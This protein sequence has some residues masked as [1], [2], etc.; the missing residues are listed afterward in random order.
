MLIS[1][2]V[3]VSD[4]ERKKGK[5]RQKRKLQRVIMKQI[6]HPISR[7]RE[8]QLDSFPACRFMAA[9]WGETERRKSAQLRGS[10]KYMH[11]YYYVVEKFSHP[12]LVEHVSFRLSIVE[13]K[14]HSF[15]GKTGDLFRKRRIEWKLLLCFA[16]GCIRNAT[17]NI[18]S[19]F[20]GSY[21]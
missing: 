17:Q 19:N 10:N 16:S 7:R 1:E 14:C 21:M 12:S 6:T 18:K 13:R 8:S 5:E 2:Q 20:C 15:R 9:C 3:W 4:K 11:H